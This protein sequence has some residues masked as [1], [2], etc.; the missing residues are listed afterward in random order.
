MVNAIKGKN[1]AT[2][3]EKHVC[4]RLAEADEYELSIEFTPWKVKVIHRHFIMKVC[5]ILMQLSSTVV[6]QYVD[7]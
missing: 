4:R 1:A 7:I 3:D 2:Y 5:S 6:A